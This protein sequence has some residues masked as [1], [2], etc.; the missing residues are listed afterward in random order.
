[1]DFGVFRGQTLEAESITVTGSY[2]KT[3]VEEWAASWGKGYDFKIL[4]TGVLM[5]QL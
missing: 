2:F 4:C 1:M 5:R 3:A